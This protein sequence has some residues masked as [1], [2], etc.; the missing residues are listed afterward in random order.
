MLEIEYL[1]S[2]NVLSIYN[3]IITIDIE[4][5]DFQL[6]SIELVKKEMP[7]EYELYKEDEK[8]ILFIAWHIILTLR[9]EALLMAL[10]QNL[11]SV[12]GTYPHWVAEAV[13]RNVFIRDILVYDIDEILSYEK[14]TSDEKIEAI[15]FYLKRETLIRENGIDIKITK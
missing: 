6:A 1:N 4:E 9:Q 3:P 7:E 12:A 10:P 15:R 13:N 2:K 5:K 14:M 11:Y 8:L